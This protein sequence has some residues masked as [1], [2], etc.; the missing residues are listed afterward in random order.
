MGALADAIQS[1]VPR[2]FQEATP[3]SGLLISANVTGAE[4]TVDGVMVAVLRDEPVRL[5]DLSPGPH[6]LTVS[7]PGHFDWSRRIQLAPG[8]TLE[9]EARLEAPPVASET[10]LSPL[11][12]A[13]LLPR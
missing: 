13:G 7:A 6:R 11:L 2:L 3:R 8:T 4:V 9:I 10:R 5:A 1:A 12:W